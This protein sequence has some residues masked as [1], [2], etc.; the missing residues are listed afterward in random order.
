LTEFYWLD[1][2]QPGHR[3]W[4]GD[5]AFYLGLAAQQGGAI[6][7]G[8]VVS[9]ALF[10][11]FLERVNWLDPLFTDLPNSSL[12][13]DVDDFRQLQAIAQQIQRAIQA[14]PLPPSWL[15]PLQTAALTLGSAHLM[16]RPSIA[17]QG[18][19]D[20][21]LGDR[22]VGLFDSHVC[23]AS[24][25]S[26][27]QA[28]RQSW[29]TLFR[30]KSLF[31]WQRLGIPLQRV[32]LAVL[33]QPLWNAHAAG[34]VQ[35]TNEILNVQAVWGLGHG[36]REGEVWPDEYQLN[37][38]TQTITRWQVASQSYQY[39]IAPSPGQERPD[40]LPPEALSDRP[41]QREA[42]STADSPQSV[43]TQEQVHALADLSR[44]L[45][46][47]LEMPLRLEW[48]LHQPTVPSPSASV[49]FYL[50]QVSPQRRPSA[51][52]SPATAWSVATQPPTPSSRGSGGND[53]PGDRPPI[54]V[55]TGAAPGYALGRVQVVTAGQVLVPTAAHPTIVVTPQITPEQLTALQQ[56][57]GIISEQ[58]GLTSHAAI[59]ARELGIPAVV[60]AV[61]ATQR[62]A[63]GE[64]VLVDGDRGEVHQISSLVDWLSMPADHGTAAPV[65]RQP[66]PPPHAPA[67]PAAEPPL[68]Q[69]SSQLHL[70]HTVP[71]LPSALREKILARLAASLIQ[72]RRA[73]ATQL[74]VNLSQVEALPRTQDL[75]VD[76]VGLLRSEHML[77]PVLGG[78]HPQH[79]LQTGRR[80]ELADILAQRLRQFA[81]AFAPRP[82]F[83]RSLD[84]RA[85]DV[86]SLMSSPTVI[87]NPLLG[88]HGTLSY[89][90][91]P[92]VFDVELAALQQVHQAGLG[93]VHLIL[94]FVRSVEEFTFCQRRVGQMG[95]SS[96]PNFQLWIMAEVPSVIW[97]L[98]AY[99]EAGVQGVSI[100]SN[101]LTQLLLAADRTLDPA[102][103]PTQVPLD[104]NHPVVRQ[105]IAHIVQQ[106]VQANLPCSICGQ[107]PSQHLD[108]IPDLI[109]WGITSISVSPDRID[110]V[111]T[112]IAEAERHLLMR[113][114]QGQP[115]RDAD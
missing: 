32:Q 5:K 84:L 47:A 107:A 74:M 99:I 8:L 15:Q 54:I 90:H 79:W 94:P 29:S 12:H 83:Y 67:A 63:T 33:V 102:A 1:Q 42:I 22:T 39:G 69:F 68:S 70:G 44:R 93:N 104:Q 77:L 34:T 26:L 25:E 55:A 97:L 115:P 48:I 27:S 89:Q 23:E 92:A 4:V 41:I 50:T 110:P 46:D 103:K 19:T 87:P 59:I 95:L 111:R 3:Q 75:A 40:S 43:L 100:G 98:P 2:I 76:G 10:R 13:L 80:Q 20:P 18:I 66:P 56:V 60:G 101:D 30:A 112:A 81:E 114:F 82:V 96:N 113:V 85:D 62:F 6:V 16:L 88:L 35:A 106:T 64:V 36:L 31:Y 71:E 28:L 65:R 72:D 45:M 17:L 57:A 108:L 9:A 21:T 53:D 51:K 109:S 14:E 52:P 11:E 49:P 86:P 38:A 105:A 73:S 7:P 91:D 61:Q 78:Q 58:G 24:A 37:P